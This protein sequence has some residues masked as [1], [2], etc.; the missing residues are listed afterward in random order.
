MAKDKR[1]RIKG[2]KSTAGF[3]GLPHHIL[4]SPAYLSLDGW[5]VK[6]LVDITS[7]YHGYNNGDL[8]IAWTIMKLKGWRSRATLNNAR[9]KL[10]ARG[11]IQLTRQGGR[12]RPS[13]YGITWQSIDECK[14]K[15][16]IGPTDRPSN[17][18]REYQEEA[19]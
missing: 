13:L 3:M 19:A 2:R 15:L 17:Q 7:Q 5:A 18:W 10:L 16:E 11:L 6:L 8:A 4:G 14:G 12:N 9:K 1:A